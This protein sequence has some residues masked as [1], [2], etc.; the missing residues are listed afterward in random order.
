MSQ[1][2]LLMRLKV[3]NYTLSRGSISFPLVTRKVYEVTKRMNQFLF[4]KLQQT[5]DIRYGIYPKSWIPSIRHS[6]SVCVCVCV[7]SEYTGSEWQSRWTVSNQ[8]LIQLSLKLMDVLYLYS[9][10]S[11][12]F[13]MSIILIDAKFLSVSGLL[14]WPFL[15]TF[16]TRSFLTPHCSLKTFSLLSWKGKQLLF[17]LFSFLHILISLL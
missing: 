7:Y 10:A 16:L 13:H 8:V 2:G 15:P 5:S 14:L 6:W 11:K 12:T 3:N 17:S 1:G 4:N 9:S